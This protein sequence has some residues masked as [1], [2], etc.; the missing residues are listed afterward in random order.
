M[1]FLTAPNEVKDSAWIS[2]AFFVPRG[3]GGAGQQL[4]R[5]FVTADMKY[6]DTT[7]GGNKAINPKSQFTRYADPKAPSLAVNSDGMG[8]YYSKAYDDTATRIALRFGGPRNNALST[9]LANAYDKG[10]ADLVNKGKVSTGIFSAYTIGKALGTIYTMPLQVYFGISYLYRRVNTAITGRPYSKFYY[11]EPQMPLYWS[12]VNTIA[13]QIAANMGI[14]HSYET[15]D[16][17]DAENGATPEQGLTTAQ[18]RSLNSIIPRVL[19]NGDGSNHIDVKAISSRAQRLQNEYY[20][21]IDAISKDT[22]LDADGFTEAV[23]AALRTKSLSSN[24]R[25]ADDL[26]GY[27]KA[28]SSSPMGKSSEATTVVPVED[29]ETKEA[30]EIALYSEAIRP[31]KEEASFMDLLQAELREGSAFINYEVTYNGPVSESFSSS[32]QKT[33]LEETTNSTAQNMR[34]AFINFG[35]GNVGDNFAADALEAA[36]GGVKNLIAGAATS[37]GFGG[38]ALL[39]GSAY[40]DMP[41]VWQNSI[42]EMPT[43][44]YTIKLRTPYGNKMSVFLKLMLPL[45][46]ILAGALPR[47]AGKAAYG[48]PFLCSLH[49]QGRAK[50][51]LGLIDSVQIQRGTSNIGFNSAK[52]PTAIDITINIK[53]LDQI[54]HVPISD[55]FTSRLLSFSHFDEDTAL[56]DYLTTI[57]GV[58]LYS[59]F[60]AAPRLKLAWSKTAADW[61]SFTSPSYFAQYAAHSAPGQLVSAILAASPNLEGI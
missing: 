50:V 39:G 31:K 15:G 54:M 25:V 46:G 51:S 61:N 6:Y 1:A 9:F 56:T 11:M 35:N 18:V 5:P 52:L 42:A 2:Q 8:R 58:D 16:L 49:S 4:T 38:L 43:E 13:N 26:E 21:V 19:S 59:Q 3:L 57:S 34:N 30:T 23:Q 36:I 17:Q 40:I 14:I 29:G 7:P 37:F 12:T 45:C 22:S 20:D 48:S 55:S 32:T 60:Y 44:S 33:G 53:N 41:E 10:L 24:A 27:M 28:Y 47:S